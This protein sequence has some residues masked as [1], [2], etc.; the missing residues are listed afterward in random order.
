MALFHSSARF[1]LLLALPARCIRSAEP[2]DAESSASKAT[3]YV[4]RKRSI[5]G[6]AGHPMIFL[7]RNFAGVL[8][9]GNYAKA[10]VPGGNAVVTATVAFQGGVTPGIG[11]TS[12]DWRRLG[13]TDKARI[14]QCRGELNR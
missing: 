5:V 8:H 11:C 14:A 9:V 10:E 7:N 1:V 2:P 4:Y 3:V 12:L 6:A 13:E